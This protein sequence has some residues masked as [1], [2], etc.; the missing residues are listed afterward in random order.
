MHGWTVML[1]TCKHWNLTGATSMNGC[2][3]K[4]KEIRF[5]FRYLINKKLRKSSE[6][7]WLLINKNVCYFCLS[8][9]IKCMKNKTTIFSKDVFSNL[10][11]YSSIGL[12]YM[13]LDRKDFVQ[14]SIFKQLCD[15]LT[16]YCWS[17]RKRWTLQQRENSPYFTVFLR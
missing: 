8:I 4:F 7:L 15:Y 3:C 12:C 13:T 17:T 9:Y 11:L 2:G 1:Y 10:Y 5:K 6:Y 14:K 16:Q